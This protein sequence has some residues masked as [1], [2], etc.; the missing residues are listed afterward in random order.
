MYVDGKKVEKIKLLDAFIGLKLE[1]G[2]HQIEFKYQTVGF[3]EGAII[4]G[5]SIAILI[6]MYLFILF[7]NNGFKFRKEELG[8]RED[9]IEE[10]DLDDDDE[11]DENDEDDDEEADNDD[12]DTENTD[13]DLHEESDTVAKSGDEVLSETEEFKNI[14]T[15][16]TS[17]DPKI[18]DVMM[19][20]AS[21]NTNDE[22]NKEADTNSDGDDKE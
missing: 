6:L 17:R 16:D 4:S 19:H 2:Q 15:K 13:K 8:L 12:L 7:K 21:A 10:I 1:K 14:N 11:S 5:A 18:V 22:G 20:I 9:E 3:K